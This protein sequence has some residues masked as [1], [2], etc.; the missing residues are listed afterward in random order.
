MDA[1]ETPEEEIHYP[2]PSFFRDPRLRQIKPICQLKSF[3]E[4]AIMNIQ[5]LTKAMLHWTPMGRSGGYRFELFPEF[6]GEKRKMSTRRYKKRKTRM[7][8][9]KMSRR[10]NR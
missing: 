6:A 9:A 2:K 4:R 10:V 8:M 7:N 1:Q 3:R 5:S